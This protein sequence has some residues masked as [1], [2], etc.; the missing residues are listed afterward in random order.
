[1]RLS[2][3][4]IALGAGCQCG[5]SFGAVQPSD[6]EQQ[7]VEYLLGKHPAV[8]S[9]EHSSLDWLLGVI[10]KGGTH[11]TLRECT[12]L[13]DDLERSVDSFEVVHRVG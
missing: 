2:Q 6:Y 4:H 5:A 8:A 3:G 10:G 1:M 7:I 13:L 12:A 9:I 11:L